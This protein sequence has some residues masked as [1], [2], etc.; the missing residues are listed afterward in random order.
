MA[1]ARLMNEDGQN[2]CVTLGGSGKV[3]HVDHF[4]LDK[5]KNNGIRI[6]LGGGQDCDDWRSN[7]LTL[8][9]SCDPTADAPKN[10][11]VT[12]MHFCFK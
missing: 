3:I 8:E 11:N 9:I 2:E 12:E 7:D 10:V 1:V 5:E 4:I 6:H